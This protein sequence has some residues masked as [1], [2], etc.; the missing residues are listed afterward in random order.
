MD[1]EHLRLE[2]WE[3][4]RTNREFPLWLIFKFVG[5]ADAEWDGV[6]YLRHAGRDLP[7]VLKAL[8]THPTIDR[9]AADLEIAP[10]ELRAALWYCIWLVEH[11]KPPAASEEW[12]QRVD[13]AWRTRILNIPQQ[14]SQ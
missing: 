9:L 4:N 10:D 14:R 8:E 3:D 1:E 5:H 7:S 12:N 2:Y 6:P 13:E 11:R